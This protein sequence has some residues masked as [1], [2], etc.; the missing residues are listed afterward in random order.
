IATSVAVHSDIVAHYVYNHGS[1]AQKRRYLPQMVS[2]ECVGAIAMTEPGAGSDLQGIKTTAKRDGDDYV[3]NGSKTFI[4]NGQHC[5]LVVIVARTNPDVAGSKGTS[6]FLVDA[7]TP[8]F[9]RGRNLD[10]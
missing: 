2:G 10:K 8:G 6:L 3:I 7:A 5:D 4:T 9:R 1:D